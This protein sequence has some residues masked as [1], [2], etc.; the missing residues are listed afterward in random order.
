MTSTSAGEYVLTLSCPDRVGIVHA[1]SGLLAS[2]GGNIV[3]AQQFGDADT[4]RFF[5]RVKVA[6]QASA[7]ALR[8]AFEPV[9]AAFHM[10]WHLYDLAV[11]SGLLVMVSREGHCLNDLLYRWHTGALRAD[12]KLVVSNHM[13]FADLVGSYGVPYLHLPVT[14]DSKSAQERKLLELVEQNDVDLVVLARYMQVLSADVCDRL[15]GRI[16]NIHHSFLPSFRGARP[17]HQAYERGVKVIGATAHYVT[18]DLDEGPII[19]QEVVRVDHSHTPEDL[20]AAGR[21]VECLALSRAVRWHLE[22][23]VLVDGVKTVVFR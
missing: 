6:A 3:E 23:R 19:E 16:I 1:V 18:M 20:A 2:Q 17:Y 14:P 21:D 13:D 12:F 15:A 10:Q 7:E 5:M 11:P 9:G 8:T 4:G 22:H